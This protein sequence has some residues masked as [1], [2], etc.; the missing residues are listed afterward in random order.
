[1]H[2]GDATRSKRKRRQNWISFEE[3]NSTHLPNVLGDL[4]E[5][6][7]LLGKK[8]VDDLWKEKLGI[9]ERDATTASSSELT[10][11]LQSHALDFLGR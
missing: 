2:F 5:I 1:M 3:N 6:W 8:D 11:H 7:I 10:A 9:S 4:V